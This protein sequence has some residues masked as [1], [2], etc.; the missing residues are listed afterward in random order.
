MHD[1]PLTVLVP[2]SPVSTEMARRLL[3]FGLHVHVGVESGDKAVMICD[4]ML[5]HLPVLLAA[6]CNSPFWD[7]RATGLQS[8]RARVLEG[9][10]TA[11]LPPPGV[12]ALRR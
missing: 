4:R 3:T 6:S 10:P 11:G 9:L 7:G 2:P 12:V 1:L 5:R 8:W